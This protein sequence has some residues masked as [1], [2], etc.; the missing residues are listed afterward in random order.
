MKETARKKTIVM[1]LIC[2]LVAMAFVACTSKEN[3]EESAKATANTKTTEKQ[4]SD[5]SAL[6]KTDAS[7]KE[8]VENEKLSIAEATLELDIEPTPEP[9]PI[10]TPE[11]TTYEGID[12]NS[13]LPGME[14]METF[15]GIINE[16]IF[17]VYNDINNKKIIV[18]NGKSVEIA[19]GDILAIFEPTG[20]NVITYDGENI[21]SLDSYGSYYSEFKF[22]EGAKITR[23][24]IS[25]NTS[26]DGTNGTMRCTIIGI[27]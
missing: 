13:T 6:T 4:A 3:S 16:P 21:E 22:E 17:V 10:P 18:E 1:L 20:W 15:H 23:S 14:W 19:E 9:T 27:N 25:I 11:A 2:L 7:T 5:T 12:M 8:S 24:T 26:H